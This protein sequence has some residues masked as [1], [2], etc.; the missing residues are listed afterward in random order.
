MRPRLDSQIWRRRALLIKT[1]CSNWHWFKTYGTGTHEV[2]YLPTRRVDYPQ[3]V[4][5]SEC[6]FQ[7]GGL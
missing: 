3:A 6:H 2:K 4:T 7:L 5:A 1:M